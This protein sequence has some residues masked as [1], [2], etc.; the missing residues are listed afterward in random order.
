MEVIFSNHLGLNKV[1][2]DNREMISLNPVERGPGK[3]SLHIPKDGK[4]IIN[5]C[6]GGKWCPIALD[7]FLPVH[8]VE[9]ASSGGSSS[10][11]TL[12]KSNLAF[13]KPGRGKSLWLAYLEKAFAKACGNYHAISGGEIVEAFSVLTGCPTEV[14]NFNDDNFNSDITWGK[15]LS[16][17]SSCFPWGPGQ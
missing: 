5:L 13:A 8:D 9:K 7:T 14:I 6:I 1:E 2:V 12:P 16:Y 17:S 3:S 15:L 11:R 4:I 10:M